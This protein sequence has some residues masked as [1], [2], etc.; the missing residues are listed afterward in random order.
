MLAGSNCE[1]LVC[2]LEKRLV[3][4]LREEGVRNTP[5]MIGNSSG[6]L[7]YFRTPLDLVRALHAPEPLTERSSSDALL[8]ALVEE[9]ARGPAG[10]L[11]QQL[12]LL[13]FIPTI[14]RTT[15]QVASAF[16]SLARDDVSQH[17][18]SVF[19]EFLESGELRARSSHLAFTIARNLR[20]RTFRWAIHE[21]RLA[22]PDESRVIV[23][24][25]ALGDPHRAAILLDRFLDQCESAGCLSPDE[26][27]LLIQ[28]KIEGVSCR[29]LAAGNGHSPVAIQHRLQRIIERL[30]RLARTNPPRQLELF[31]P[32]QAPRRTSEKIFR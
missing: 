12:L 1:C 5:G 18:L 30:R 8:L 13:V 29:E 6:I 4:E 3:E 28:A 19:L 25:E 24:D 22:T 20:R 31:P 9:N 16:S 10:S 15:T 11:W 17:A 32:L 27:H 2:R 21:S 14:H 23:N 7:R 26:R